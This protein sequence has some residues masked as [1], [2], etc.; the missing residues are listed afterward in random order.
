MSAYTEDADRLAEHNPD[1]CDDPY[2]QLEELDE[3]R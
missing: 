1:D 2:C 3:E